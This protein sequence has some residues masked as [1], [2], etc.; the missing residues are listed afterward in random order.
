MDDGVTSQVQ[1][2][3][4]SFPLSLSSSI[5]FLSMP[6]PPPVST[7][8]GESGH[9][10]KI[11]TLQKEGRGKGKKHHHASA[12][13]DK[14]REANKGKQVEEG[15]DRRREGKLV[16]LGT[17]GG[18]ALCSGAGDERLSMKPFEMSQRIKCRSGVS[19]FP[20]HVKQ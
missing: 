3:L 10:G 4:L 12:G 17:E 18:A 15:K 2:P 16:N 11:K 7:H 20:L 5:N 6:P 9:K 14:L 19:L 1:P 13:E 8:G